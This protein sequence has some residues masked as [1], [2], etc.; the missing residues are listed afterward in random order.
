MRR[1]HP[2]KGECLLEITATK[3]TTAFTLAILSYDWELVRNNAQFQALELTHQSRL[4][5]MFEAVAPRIVQS[6]LQPHGTPGEVKFGTTDFIPDSRRLFSALVDVLYGLRNAL[7]H[8]SITPTREHN[9]VYA[10]A[11]HLVMRLVRCTI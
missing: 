8:G 3:S 4:K 7:F 1:D 9:E 5:V 10:P 11:Y 6:V 2:N